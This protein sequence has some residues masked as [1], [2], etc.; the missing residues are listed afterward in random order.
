MKTA[1]ARLSLA[2]AALTLVVMVYAGYEAR[3]FRDASMWFPTLVAIL[4]T[5][6]ALVIIV[7]DLRTLRRDHPEEDGEERVDAGTL[8]AFALWMGWFAGLLVLL[9]ALG[10]VIGVPIWL[11]AFLRFGSRLSL[12]FSL[13]GAVV[14]TALLLLLSATLDFHLPPGP[15]GL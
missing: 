7:M 15:F 10:G 5:I 11:F 12:S 14:T 6:T 13:G 9:V 1:Q 2:V 3:G 8:R 4:G